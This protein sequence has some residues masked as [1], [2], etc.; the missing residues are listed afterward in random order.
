[1][2]KSIKKLSFNKE[3]IAHLDSD[4]LSRVKAGDVS[5]TPVPESEATNCVNVYACN[6]LS[7][8]DGCLTAPKTTRA[9]T[10]IG[11]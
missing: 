6:P 7:H 11:C 9:C 1:M 10:F 5:L 8:Y 4:L 3:T 2:K